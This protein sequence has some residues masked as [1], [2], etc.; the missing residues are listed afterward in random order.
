M[1]LEA[2]AVF[3][4]LFARHLAAR[5]RNKEP[6]NQGP[7]AKEAQLVPE[8]SGDR[9]FV[10]MVKPKLDTDRT[11]SLHGLPHG[12]GSLYSEGPRQVHPCA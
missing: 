5:G 2:G 12:S 6:Q 3:A 11:C 4:E 7:V 9:P 10:L 8:G 1:V